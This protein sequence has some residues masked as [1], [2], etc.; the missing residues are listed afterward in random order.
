MPH[1]SAL[2]ISVSLLGAAPAAVL[3]QDAPSRHLDSISFYRGA[4][5][6]LTTPDGDA[7]QSC[8]PALVRNLYSDG[9]IGYSFIRVD[10]DSH[11]QSA[12]SFLGNG[13][14]MAPGS[15]AVEGVLLNGPGGDESY[16][17]RGVCTRAGA[18]D[19]PQSV[20]CEAT[21]DNGMYTATFVSD[22]SAPQVRD[23]KTSDK[24]KA[25]Q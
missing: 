12:V 25:A 6:S 1:Y 5:H 18:D 4:C 19:G 2:L 13:D 21:T 22:G 16:D 9:D 15:I 20:S 10:P 14:G 8:A 11:A 23:M 24:P 7:S 17:G 3:A